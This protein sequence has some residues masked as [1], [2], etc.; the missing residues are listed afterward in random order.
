MRRP[1]KTTVDLID[2]DTEGRI[3]RF[4]CSRACTHKIEIEMS[5]GAMSALPPKADIVERD[6]HVCFVPNSEILRLKA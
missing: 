2:D 3:C 5:N 6:R 4:G 1:N